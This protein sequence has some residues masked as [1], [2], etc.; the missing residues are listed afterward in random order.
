MQAS[1]DTEPSL[2]DAVNV[3]AYNAA[4]VIPSIEQLVEVT[5]NQLSLLL[6]KSLGPITRG[7]L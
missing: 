6:G 2:A 1:A 7:A 4:Q 3:A 5:E